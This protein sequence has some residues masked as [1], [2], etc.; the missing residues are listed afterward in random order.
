M[1]VTAIAFHV[2]DALSHTSIF[3][4]VLCIPRF[5]RKL[6]DMKR[7]LWKISILG[8]SCW[9]LD[10]LNVAATS[11]KKG[12][13]GVFRRNLEKFLTWIEKK[14]R[15]WRWKSGLMHVKVGFDHAPKRYSNFNNIITQVSIYHTNE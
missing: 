8:R 3:H 12:K 11:A 10:A 5:L 14:D 13:K 6:S 1:P 4:L 9:C 2:I 15:Y 7:N